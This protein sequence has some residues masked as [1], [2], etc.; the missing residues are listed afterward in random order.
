MKIAF[1]ILAIIACGVA[2]YFSLSHSEKFTNQQQVR[3]DTIETNRAVVASTEAANTDI[4]RERE[5][6]AVSIERRDTLDASVQA[7]KSTGKTLKDEVDELNGELLGQKEEMDGLQA[8][9]EEVRK[10]LEGFGENVDIDTLPD[11]IKSLQDERDMR[12]KKKDELEV[13]IVAAEK[14][15]D[16]KQAE[17]QRLAE[18][19]TSRNARLSRNASEAVVT[20]VDQEWGFLVIGAGSNSGFTPQTDLL[21]K[22]DGRFIGRVKPSAIERT[23]T[24]AEIIFD[25]LSPGVRLQ[26]GD[27][28]LLA[29]PAAN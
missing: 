19:K 26:P 28:V 25:S 11:R 24:I 9:L 20:A 6:L 21:V 29:K 10:I 13:L 3:L 12:Q 8:S 2:A 1:H 17:S 15:V 16:A 18:R 23:Q 5:L 27:R 4:K 7:L 14:S 22:R